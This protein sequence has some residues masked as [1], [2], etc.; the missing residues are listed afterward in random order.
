[1]CELIRGGVAAIFGPM[2]SKPAILVQTIADKYEI[3]HLL[4]RNDFIFYKKRI[5]VNLHPNGFT[6]TRAIIDLVKNLQWQDFAVV[7]E[8]N[9]GK[10][11]GFKEKKLKFLLTSLSYSS[12]KSII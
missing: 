10:F 7:Y 9:D 5:S 12:L 3:P 6:I 11:T 2:Q 4:L 1:M 8:S